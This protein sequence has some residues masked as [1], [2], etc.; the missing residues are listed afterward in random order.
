[1]AITLIA[2][3]LPLA[4]SSCTKTE[5]IPSST[6][7]LK[8]PT[9]NRTQERRAKERSP[10]ED[11]EIDQTDQSEEEK[12]KKAQIDESKLPESQKRLLKRRKLI[13]NV[14]PKDKEKN[15]RIEYKR[16]IVHELSK[17]WH[18]MKGDEAPLVAIRVGQYGKI[19]N[20]K[21]RR[22]SGDNE[23]DEEVIKAVNALN[24]PPFDEGISAAKLAFRIDFN[25]IVAKQQKDADKVLSRTSS[26]GSNK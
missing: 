18:L 17:H 4:F 3:L 15:L 5:P 14:T 20:V 12:L 8:Q 6:T 10:D 24:L 16:N 2:L 11:E 7:S 1:M 9:D 23:V 26:P 13:S 22:S 19:Q 21:I 25:R